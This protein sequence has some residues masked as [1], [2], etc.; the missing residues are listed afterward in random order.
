MIQTYSNKLVKPPFMPLA[1]LRRTADHATIIELLR[2]AQVA[3]QKPKYSVLRCA[4]SSTQLY[5]AWHPGNGTEE[6]KPPGLAEE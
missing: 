6:R 4:L 5:F 2:H 3:K 1:H